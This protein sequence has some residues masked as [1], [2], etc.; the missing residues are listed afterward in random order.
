MEENGALAIK[1][2]LDK[3]RNSLTLAE[4]FSLA[5]AV[6]EMLT[7][8]ELETKIRQT[9]HDS[10]TKLVKRINDTSS[11]VT[12]LESK[13]DGIAQVDFEFKRLK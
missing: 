11:K 2:L 5:R 12:L 9:V 1:I 3:D 10:N 13:F 7:D 8:Y 6:P 4:L